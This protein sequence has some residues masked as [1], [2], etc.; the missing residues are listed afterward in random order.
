MLGLAF[1][2]LKFLS[3]NINYSKISLKSNSSPSSTKITKLIKSTYI[4]SI[5][6]LDQNSEIINN[7]QFIN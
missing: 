4:P 2:K 1:K 7:F 5:S 6:K 3:I